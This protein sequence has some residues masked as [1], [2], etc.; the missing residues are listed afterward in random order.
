MVVGECQPPAHSLRWCVFVEC[1]CATTADLFSTSE[2]SFL[3][4]LLTTSRAAGILTI[5]LGAVLFLIYL[6]LMSWSAK[7]T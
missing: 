3:C 7:L 6:V 5:G 2:Q 1:R 4:M